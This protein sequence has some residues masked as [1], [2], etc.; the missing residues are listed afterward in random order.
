M[1]KRQFIHFTENPGMAFGVELPGDSGKL[2][3]SLFRI[4]AVAGIGYYLW[5]LVK[6]RAPK[7]LIASI[8]LILAGALGNIID[9]AFYGLLFSESTSYSVAT[10]LPAD[11]G[12]APLLHGKVVDMLWFPLSKGILPDWVPFWGGEPYMFFRPVFN[13]ADS[14]ITIG[15]IMIILFQRRYFVKPP[16]A[17]AVE[18]V[19]PAP[20][21]TAEL[22]PGNEAAEVDARNEATEAPE[23]QTST[24]KPISDS[25][26]D[27]DKLES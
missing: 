2:I 11:G 19:D 4:A 14:A 23:A 12:Y 20:T 18:T 22:E 13:V 16:E 10:F 8:S 1:Y 24:E 9:S 26:S 6:E 7:G 21:A 27:D 25:T 15:V 17:E 3:L 5:L